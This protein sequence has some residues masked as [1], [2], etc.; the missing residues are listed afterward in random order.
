MDTISARDQHAQR[1][2]EIFA[3]IGAV[4]SIGEQHDLAPLRRADRPGLNREHVA[5]PFRQRTLRVDT[6]DFLEQT[7]QQRAVVA[8]I[9]ERREARRQRCIARQKADQPIPQRKSVFRHPRG[10]N[11]DLHFG[12]VDAGGAFVAAGLA[13]HAEF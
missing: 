12:H 6:G 11:F 7:S 9:G 1:G 10:Q 8:P 4:E 2:V 3:L 5:P 13:G